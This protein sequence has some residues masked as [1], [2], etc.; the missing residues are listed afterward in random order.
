MRVSRRSFALGALAAPFAS[1][2]AAC[3]SSSSAGT[4]TTTGPDGGALGDGGAS[5]PTD[6]GPAFADSGPAGQECAPATLVLAL[7]SVDASNAAQRVLYSWTTEA[8]I[9]ELRQNPTLLTRTLTENGDPGTLW[10]D[11]QNRATNGSNSARFL[12]QARYAKSRFGWVSPVG[13]AHVN[14]RDF[15]YGDRLL[16]I[17]LR[18]EALVALVRDFDILFVDMNNQQV[19]FEV[20]NGAPERL[21]AIFYD[22]GQACGEFDAP[23]TYREYLIP[24]E[25]MIESWEVAT[26]AIQA[27]VQQTSKAIDDFDGI[28]T[29]R[30]CI[31][32][33]RCQ[34]QAAF[35]RPFALEISRTEVSGI[36]RALRAFPAQGAPLVHTL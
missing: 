15:P 11:L 26:A 22:N 14:G 16:K 12:V 9:A 27:T 13:F 23:G 25:A 5:N 10:T 1:F 31:L 35:Y 21:G 30:N 6:G 4:E 17:T 28:L 32:P 18:P 24:N 3:G 2:A 34:A 19:A 7:P 8:Q 20:P 36:A 29:S 33:G